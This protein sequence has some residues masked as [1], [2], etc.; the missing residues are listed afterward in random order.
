VSVPVV[1][2]PTLVLVGLCLLAASILLAG[3]VATLRIRDSLATC[4]YHGCEQRFGR[5][6]A[7]IAHFEEHDR[8][9][10]DT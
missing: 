1:S 5:A 3:F 8:A 9:S 2:G 6:R 10:S 7:M 4:P